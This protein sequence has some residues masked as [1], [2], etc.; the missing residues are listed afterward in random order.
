MLERA[1][2]GLILSIFWTAVLSVG[3]KAEDLDPFQ[4]SDKEMISTYVPLERRFGSGRGVQ[5]RGLRY[6][7]HL[8]V[9]LAPREKTV[10]INQLRGPAAFNTDSQVAK[11]RENLSVCLHNREF[12]AYF[13]QLKKTVQEGK[14]VAD[15]EALAAEDALLRC[16][17]P[18]AEEG[19]MFLVGFRSKV[20]RT[21][22]RGASE[23]IP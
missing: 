20:M 4:V 18:F 10:G 13:S 14:T 22:W 7:L 11:A 15:S 23:L 5:S 3:A 8:R 12:E 9:Q 21:Q 2:I 6:S 17:Q 1:V 19:M 16:L